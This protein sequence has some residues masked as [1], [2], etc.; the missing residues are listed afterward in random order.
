MSLSIFWSLNYN[1]KLSRSEILRLV[2]TMLFFSCLPKAP[3]VIKN[4]EVILNVQFVH[5][6]QY[7]PHFSKGTKLLFSNILQLDTK[8]YYCSI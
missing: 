3:K 4:T 5:T 1:F 7:F 6:C 8:H 2:K